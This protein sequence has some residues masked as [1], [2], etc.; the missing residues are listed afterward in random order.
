MRRVGHDRRRGADGD[1]QFRRTGPDGYVGEHR[2][3][4]LAS[5]I[6]DVS[7]KGR[8]PQVGSGIWLSRSQLR[9]WLAFMGVQQRLG[10][11]MNR[12][13]QADNE[14]SLADYDV[15]N[16]LSG[17]PG[18]CLQ[19]SALAARIGW[20]RSRVSHHAKRM[21]SRGLVHCDV[22]ASDRR[23]TEVRLTPDGQ[24]A[25]V[26]AAPGHV[27]LVRNLFF[28]GLPTELIV[29]LSQALEAIYDNIVEHGTLPAP[30]PE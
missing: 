20:E 3:R 30:A 25:I 24:R 1:R 21:Q 28:G 9:T 29:P 4:S 2:C 13:L 26:E 11:E 15:L 12:Q 17:A 27:D 16:A 6:C 18:G 7:R 22:A 5:T 19:V 23:A 8:Q 10:Y 14:L